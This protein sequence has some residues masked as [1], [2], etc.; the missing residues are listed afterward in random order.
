M[1]DITLAHAGRPHPARQPQA[2]LIR[3]EKLPRGLLDF[4]LDR[5]GPR[6][7]QAAE[8][9]LIEQAVSRHIQAMPFVWLSVPDRA[10]RGYVERNSIAVT[11]C[12][13]GGADPPSA[14]WLGHCAE[15]TEICGSGLW[16][17]DHIRNRCDP[18]FL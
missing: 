11:S 8:E 7:G 1:L 5:H 3:R 14:S 18:G 12:L 6:P 13:A 2:A 4:W 9:A 17:V 16:N 15:R 10:D